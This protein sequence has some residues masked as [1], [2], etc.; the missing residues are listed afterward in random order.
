LW[1]IFENKKT[2]TI[3]KEEGSGME[4]ADFPILTLDKSMEIYHT[5][6]CSSLG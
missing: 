5:D 4:Y 3:K 2:W 6:G 1:F